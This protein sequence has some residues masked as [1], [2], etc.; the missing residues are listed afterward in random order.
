MCPTSGGANL[1]SIKMTKLGLMKTLFSIHNHS[2]FAIISFAVAQRS[3]YD[4]KIHVDTYV[5]MCNDLE[6][7]FNQYEKC[8]DLSALM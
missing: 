7:M 3:R 4:M 1:V 8:V 2:E 5:I 6:N